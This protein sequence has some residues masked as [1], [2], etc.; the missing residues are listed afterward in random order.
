MDLALVGTGQM[1][2]A[3]AD[4]ASSRGHAVVA[5]FNADRPL[6]EADGPEALGGADLVVD[7]SLPDVALPHM[8]RYC[9]WG[10][11]A[12][13]GTTGW[14][15]RLDEVQ[16]LVDEHDATLLY[17]PNF[18]IG[19]ALLKQAVARLG[20]LLDQLDDYDVAV[21]ET[22]HTRKAD[23]PSGTAQMLGEVLR[24]ALERKTHLD[25][26]AQHAP[27]DDAA[28]HVTS[29]RLGSVFGEHDVILDSPFD[30]ITLRHQAKSREGFAQGAVRA[31]EWLPGRQG[32]FTLDDVLADWLA[33]TDDAKG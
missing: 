30:Q 2:Q 7:F 19:V 26:E 6:T 21:R 14:Y 9:R 24:D 33:A 3:V 23:S 4:C 16:A 18:S 8:R 29:T 32:L 17:A 5:R 20:P 12:V 31:A 15:D 1:G 13:V 11:P 25:A 22:H 27:I 28:L 10:R